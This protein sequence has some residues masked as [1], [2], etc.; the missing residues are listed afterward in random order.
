M[1]D[2]SPFLFYLL[3]ENEE[4]IVFYSFAYSSNVYERGEGVDNERLITEH[5]EGAHGG[6]TC[7]IP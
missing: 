1:N 2:K 5:R 7:H 6:H 3:Q 4:E